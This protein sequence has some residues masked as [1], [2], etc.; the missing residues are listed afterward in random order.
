MV[1]RPGILVREDRLESVSENCLLFFRSSASPVVTDRTVQCHYP[2]QTRSFQAA[3]SV[4]HLAYS[5]W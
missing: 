4:T 5:L 3:L 2:T 1:A